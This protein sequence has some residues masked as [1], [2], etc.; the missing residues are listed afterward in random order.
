MT[1][2]KPPVPVL[3]LGETCVFNLTEYLALRPSHTSS[4]PVFTFLLMQCCSLFV[5]YI[6]RKVEFLSLSEPRFFLYVLFTVICLLFRVL[7]FGFFSGERGEGC[8]RGGEPVYFF[9]NLSISSIYNIL[10]GYPFSYSFLYPKP[11]RFGKLHGK[12]AFLVYSATYLHI[13]ISLSASKEENK[14]V[15]YTYCP[16]IYSIIYPPFLSNHQAT[17]AERICIITVWLTKEREARQIILEP[18][19]EKLFV[20]FFVPL[21]GFLYI[22]LVLSHSSFIE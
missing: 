1:R 20:S 7:V 2:L 22:I 10:Q 19:I 8:G 21:L 12:T 15:I 6:F 16:S 17:E 14:L 5:F 13:S 18:E 4:L 11:F 3:Q 9:Q